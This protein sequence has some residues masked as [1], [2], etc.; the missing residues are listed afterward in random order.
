M[1]NAIVTG[2]T[3]GIGLAIAEMLLREGYAVTVTYST[4]RESA[5]QCRN[6]LMESG[7]AFEIIQADQSDKQAMGRFAT[8]MRG[9]EHIDCL[10]CN[11]GITNRGTLK[12]MTDEVWERVMQVNVN[13]PVYLV[14]DL[15][16]CIPPNSRIVFIGSMMGLLPHSMSLAYGV[17]KAAI[18]AVARNLVKEFDGSGTTV[19]VIAP[20][21]VETA[22]H[23]N[24]PTEIRANISKKTALHRFAE[25]EEI[26][27]AVRFCLHNAY[28]NGSVLEI[29]GGYDYK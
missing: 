1:K 11:A 3:K 29:S 7:T 27:D 28:V 2:G 17:S 22:W 10:I 24:K 25:P 15:Q 4:D 8:L 20:G 9:K 13:A 14:R 18:T 16:D 12:E 5:E 19:N 23:T 6:R 21:F 26:A